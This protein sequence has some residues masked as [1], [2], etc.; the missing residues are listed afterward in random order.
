[1]IQETNNLCLLAIAF[2][3]FLTF[4][5]AAAGKKGL[6]LRLNFGKHREKTLNASSHSPF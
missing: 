1:L 2:F 6:W 4:A 3:Y 5:L